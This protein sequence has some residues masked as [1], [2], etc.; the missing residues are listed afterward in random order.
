MRD[1]LAFLSLM[2]RNGAKLFAVGTGASLV[3]HALHYIGIPFLA[4]GLY[5]FIS[6]VFRPLWK[7]LLGLANII[8]VFVTV[9]I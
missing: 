6:K 2:Q 7:F 4:H 8:L 1:F 5:K 3:I 9:T